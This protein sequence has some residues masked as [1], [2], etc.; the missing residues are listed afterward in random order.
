M[1][2]L[3]RFLSG[4]T[5]AGQVFYGIVDALPFPNLLNPVRAALSSNEN[6]DTS[7]LVKIT[8]N[9]IDNVRLVIGLIVS[10]LIISG[11]ASTE[12]VNELVSILVKILS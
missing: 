4:K 10:Y 7:E 1:K 6:L 2:K 3:K 9:K 12:T 11:K 5:K 8:W